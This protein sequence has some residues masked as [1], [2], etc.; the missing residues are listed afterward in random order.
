VNRLL[1]WLAL[2]AFGLVLGLLVLFAVGWL[3]DARGAAW[4]SGGT[5]AVLAGYVTLLVLV[6]RWLL[7]GKPGGWRLGWGPVGG[8]TP[9]DRM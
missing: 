9:P 6:K 7:P 5:I 1:R 4:G 3:V 8:A 2:L